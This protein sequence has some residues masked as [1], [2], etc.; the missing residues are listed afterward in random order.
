LSKIILEEPPPRKL[1]LVAN[2]H[3]RKFSVAGAKVGED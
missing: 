3:K 2:D 1:D